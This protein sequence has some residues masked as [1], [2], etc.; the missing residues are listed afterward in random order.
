MSAVYNILQRDSG[1]TRIPFFG[2]KF[3]I[4]T[5]LCLIFFIIYDM[6]KTIY[7]VRNF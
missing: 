3:E 1:Y 5:N 6:I 7:I 4:L 2:L